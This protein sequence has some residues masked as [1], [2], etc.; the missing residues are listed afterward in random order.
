MPKQGPSAR[1]HLPFAQPALV[2][3]LALAAGPVL[4]A[5]VDDAE[6]AE[7]RATLAAL[8]ARIAVLEAQA[9]A[10]SAGDPAPE[11]KTAPQ[12]DAGPGLDIAAAGDGA[13]HFGIGGRIH[14]EA[15]AFDRDQR[16]ATGGSEFRRA[17]FQIEGEAAG[18]GYRLQAELSGRNTDLRDV[19]LE[20]RFGDSTLTLGQFKPFRSMEDLTS[21]N[22]VALM[23]RSFNSSA[24]L[25]ADRQWQQG[26]GLLHAHGSGSL[27]VSVFNLREDNT[28]RNEG[29]GS[30]VRATWAPHFNAR[31][32]LH[33]GAW[34]SHEQG[35]RDTP[36][37]AIKP[38]YGGRRGPEALLFE[39]AAGSDFKQRSTGLELAGRRGSLHWQ[40][41]WT[42]TTL[43]GVA[44][45]AHIEGRYLE[46]G[47]LFGGVR[48][49]DRGEGVFAAPVG[50]G[51]GGL[52]ELVARGEQMHR[53]DLTG[54]AVRR[55]VLG[56]NWYASEDVRFMLNLTSGQDDATG[57]SP[58]QLALRAQYVF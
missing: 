53:R 40:G 34:W 21:S 52:W 6:L 43:T 56:L 51:P 27:G 33:L 14:Y 18:W 32:L 13:A 39:S 31:D 58:R 15:Y 54:F 1:R 10:G 36:A 44:G 42:R 25:F 23:E 19:Y 4:A 55:W 9:A 47:W 37:T 2:L 8:Q 48:A 17:R 28:P 26:L 24:G 45:E 12:L 16:P 41:E 29:W 7:L 22:D 38:A 35:G 46:A 49:Y 30:A 20:R 11:A 3:C 50:I 5:G 57:D